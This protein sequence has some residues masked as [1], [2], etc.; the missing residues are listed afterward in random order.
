MY[1]VVILDVYGK[2]RELQFNEYRN[3]MSVA[4]DFSKVKHSKVYVNNSLLHSIK[5]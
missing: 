5:Y 3:A 4:T 2:K 1:L